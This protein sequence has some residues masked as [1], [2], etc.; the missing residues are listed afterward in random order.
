VPVQYVAIHC[1]LFGLLATGTVLLARRSRRAGLVWV[2][3]VVGG[4][5]V[6]QLAMIVF[7]RSVANAL[8]WADLF[9]FH[10][11]MLHIAGVVLVAVPIVQET[12]ATRIRAS[13]LALLL[14]G[15]ALYASRDVLWA[16]GPLADQRVDTVPGAPTLVRQTET[17]TCAPAAAATL[18]RALGLDDDASERELAALSFTHP[19][20]GT[21]DLGLYRGLRLAA[22]GRRVRFG[23]RT[24]AELRAAAPCMVF[25]SLERARVPDQ[26][27]FE[28]MRDQCNWNE[29]EVHAVVCFGFGRDSRDGEARDVAVIGDPN[30]GVERWSLDHFEYLWDGTTVEVE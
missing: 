16:P 28:F 10:K 19:T 12:R 3:A 27:T 8:G 6:A 11:F 13:V 15:L 17:S 25:V 29:G 9:F 20:Q 1:L 23:S 18:L 4:G 2:G 7:G 26:K 30:Y 21:S 14:F 22:P 24:L 5:V